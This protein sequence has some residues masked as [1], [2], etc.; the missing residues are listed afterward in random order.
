[1]VEVERER[2]VGTQLAVDEPD[3]VVSLLLALLDDRVVDEQEVEAGDAEVA[4]DRLEVHHLEVGR[5]LDD[6]LV[7]VG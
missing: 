4:R 6:D 5:V 7:D 3:F 1:V 2:D